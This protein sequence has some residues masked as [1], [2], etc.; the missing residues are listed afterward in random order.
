MTKIELATALAEFLKMKIDP[1]SLP[2]FQIIRINIRGK[3]EV[4]WLDA[5]QL[6]AFIWTL[7]QKANAVTREK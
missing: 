5:D 1:G 7:V 2:L 3:K 4:D 6:M